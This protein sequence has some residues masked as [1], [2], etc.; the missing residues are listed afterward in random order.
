MNG[1]RLL[2]ALMLL[3]TCQVGMITHVHGLATWDR[4]TPPS[5]SSVNV[6][7]PQRRFVSFV[8]TLI[9]AE[10]VRAFSTSSRRSS[11]ARSSASKNVIEDEERNKKTSRPHQPLEEEK[12]AS[13]S[14]MLLPILFAVTGAAPVLAASDVTA[15]GSVGSA[16]DSS[17]SSVLSWM[18]IAATAT[19]STLDDPSIEAEVLNGMAH[20]AMDFS[21]MFSPS[22]SLYR[23]LSVIGR[24]FVI[25]ADYL[26]DHTIN[27][28]ELLIQLFLIA[29][30]MRELILGDN[31]QS[32]QEH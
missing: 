6:A 20:V 24:L 11:T 29:V 21:G 3:S 2:I 25:S 10:K 15:V 28:E 18:T 4:S 23:F 13:S 31:H 14:L 22:K 32:R 5:S 12:A 9:N 17:S 19:T 16:A 26:P 7:A 27:S 30:A 8:D 1:G